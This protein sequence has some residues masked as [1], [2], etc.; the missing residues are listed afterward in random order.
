[1]SSKSI[2]LRTEKR[3]SLLRRRRSGFIL[4]VPW[5]G[6]EEEREHT[7]K[8]IFFPQQKDIVIGSYHQFSCFVEDEHILSARGC[9][10]LR[11]GV[12]GW[13][14]VEAVEG[15]FVDLCLLGIYNE[16]FIGNWN[17]NSNNNSILLLIMEAVIFLKMNSSRYLIA[18]PA[19]PVAPSFRNCECFAIK[20]NEEGS[21]LFQTF[22]LRSICCRVVPVSRT[23]WTKW[24]VLWPS[25]WN[26][27]LFSTDNQRRIS[28]LQMELMEKEK[29][30]SGIFMKWDPSYSAMHASIMTIRSI[31]NM[32]IIIFR[33]G[34]IE[35]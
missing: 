28:R 33:L 29:F 32:M 8:L 34:F 4:I 16:S 35:Y 22:K 13:F 3:S 12:R 30:P 7:L 2:A 17:L 18:S 1:M 26:G 9:G 6:R 23:Q 5:E 25:L 10:R 19:H 31:I 14:A 24:D 27:F 15:G 21:L 11:L 20:S